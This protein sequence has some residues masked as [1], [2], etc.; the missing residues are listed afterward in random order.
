MRKAR[1]RISGTAEERYGQAIEDILNRWKNGE[2]I[3]WRSLS[4]KG[5]CAYVKAC[6]AWSDLPSKVIKTGN[7]ILDGAE[8]K[9]EIDLYCLLGEVFIGERG[10]LGQDLHGFYDCFCFSVDGPQESI[11]QPNTSVTILNSAL[12]EKTLNKSFTS[13]E[14]YFSILIEYFQKAGLTVKLC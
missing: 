14:S 10:Y 12:L 2:S 13:T 9:K 7:Y 3:D 4:K 8:V 1:F 5:K 11:V 6:L